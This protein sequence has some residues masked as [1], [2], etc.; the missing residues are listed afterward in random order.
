MK[1]IHLLPT[2]KGQRI[3]KTNKGTFLFCSVVAKDF[4]ETRKDYSGFHL[5]ITNDEEIKEGDYF[6]KPDCNMIFKAE[7][8]PHKGCQKIILTTD[9]DLIAD[10]VQAIDDTFLE[11]FVK[12]PSCNSVVVK[13]QYWK[14]INDVGKYTYKII[15]PQEEHPKQIKCYCG[16]TS[17]CDCSP[18]EEPKQEENEIID[19][20]DHDGIGNAVDN[21]N[22]EP[23]QET[24]EEAAKS[25]YGRSIYDYE[26][27]DAFV[28]GA[29][30][31]QE[32]MYS[33]EEVIEIAK[34][35]AKRCQ[36]TI[37]DTKWLNEQLKK[38]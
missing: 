15:I 30:W 4:I 26:Q 2:D 18:L 20:S 35:Y 13:Y 19:I 33:E 10:G 12:N 28:N 34:R 21:L 22:N 36:A 25:K 5:Y 23:P 27:I 16:H 38:K 32:R 37:Q 9:Q 29:K 31:Q 6:W 7:Y 1:N 24:L 17:Y 8:T 3:T 11:W 14:E